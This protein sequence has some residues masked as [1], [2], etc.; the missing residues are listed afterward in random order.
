MPP[1]DEKAP[2]EN[3]TV[4]ISD[5]V[6]IVAALCGVRHSQRRRTWRRGCVVPNGAP[7]AAA[8]NYCYQ[9]QDQLSLQLIMWRNILGQ[10]IYQL[11]V[12]LVLNFVGKKLLGISSP[13][14]R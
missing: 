5:E 9:F 11:V 13:S 4:S 12:L 10:S 8:Y 1:E 3:V 7:A 14:D 6:A 2:S